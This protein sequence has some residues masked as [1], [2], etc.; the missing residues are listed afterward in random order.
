M[1]FVDVIRLS[2]NG[3]ID[4]DS[5]IGSKN[6]GVWMGAGHT[7]R[8]V[9]RDAGDVVVRR[10]AWPR[11]LVDVGRD[12]VETIARRTQKVRSAGGGGCQNQTHGVDD[13]LQTMIPLGDVATPVIGAVLRRQPLSDAKIAFAWRMAVGAAMA[14]V[15][16]A[17]LADDGRLV[18][19]VDDLQW[20]QEI[21]RTSPMIRP[22]LDD[23]LGAGV[24]LRIDVRATFHPP[25][26]PR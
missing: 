2:G 4:H 23:L 3:S 17:T 6:A 11:P 12:H 10:L 19:V 7:S 1:G 5:R 22:R 21:R 8:L 13:T 16:H 26:S 9:S 18:V 20:R 15:S 25:R 14:R 24:V